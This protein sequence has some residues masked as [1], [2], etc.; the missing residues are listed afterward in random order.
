[1]HLVDNS[2][3]AGSL[4]WMAWTSICKA[5][6]ACHAVPLLSQVEGKYLVNFQGVLP[7][8]SSI[9]RGVHFWEGPFALMVS[10]G[11]LAGKGRSVAWNQEIETPALPA[12]AG[13]PVLM[14]E[15]RGTLGTYRGTLLIR[16][17]QASAGL[18]DGMAW[19]RARQGFPW[20]K[21]SFPGWESRASQARA[22]AGKV[23]TKRLQIFL[24]SGVDLY[25][26]FRND[27][28]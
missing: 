19:T 2:R 4:A 17:R 1:M 25:H 18:T 20:L 9:L 6:R 24:F 22:C 28:F 10:P 13:T 21:N 15:D 8:S 16:K 12:A 26:D 3:Q 7:D 23:D 27:A 11:W 14:R 5:R